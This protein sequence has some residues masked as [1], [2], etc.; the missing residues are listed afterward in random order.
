MS[1]KLY[2]VR[3]PLILCNGKINYLTDFH[4]FHS[5]YYVSALVERGDYLR[6]EMS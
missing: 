2:T 6:V 1:V 5:Y 4:S 3:H